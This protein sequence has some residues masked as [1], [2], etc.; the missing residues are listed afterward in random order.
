[1]LH[2][3]QHSCF[4]FTRSNFFHSLIQS[5]YFDRRLLC[6]SSLDKYPKIKHGLSLVPTCSSFLQIVSIDTLKYLMSSFRQL[7]HFNLTN[8]NI[9]DLHLSTVYQRPRYLKDGINN[10]GTLKKQTPFPQKVVISIVR[11]TFT[12]L[13]LFYCLL[14]NH[15]F[16]TNPNSIILTFFINLY[17]LFL[18]YNQQ[19][20]NNQHKS[21]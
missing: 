9:N 6:I 10:A 20:N 17:S 4:L 2:E 12:S 14:C 8:C 16:P 5:S 3:P 19:T 18:L 1:M 13:L 15:S 7:L 21:Q 11:V